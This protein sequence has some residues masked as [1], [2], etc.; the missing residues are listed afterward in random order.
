MAK[1]IAKWFYERKGFGFIE[2]ANDP[3]QFVHFSA[4]T[5]E[6]FKTL[7]EGEEVVFDVEP[8]RNGPAA[9]KANRS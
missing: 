6:G 5:G 2:Q 8:G 3:G 7:R 4:I 1:G 9:T